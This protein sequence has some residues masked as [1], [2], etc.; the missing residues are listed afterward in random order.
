MSRCWTIGGETDCEIIVD[1]PTVS[2]RHCRLIRFGD[3]YLLEDLG[4]T[5]GTFV[6]GVRV[7]GRRTVTVHDSVTLGP[8]VPL[9]WPT[10][11]TAHRT[12]LL[13]GREPQNDLIVDRPSVSGC[14]ALVS[15]DPVRGEA[16]IE[17]LG[18]ANGTAIGSPTRKITRAVLS[19]VDTI[20]LG[21]EP[22]PAAHVL[23]Q[24]ATARA[25]KVVFKG[26]EMVIG[27]DPACQHVI[28]S[29]Q[30]SGRH[31][32]L[33]RSGDQVLIEDLRSSNGTFVNGRRIEKPVIIRD[34]DSIGL[35]SFALE[36]A[37]DR[38]HGGQTHAAARALRTSIESVPTPHGEAPTPSSTVRTEFAR[39]FEKPWRL[40]LLGVH[41][42]LLAMVVLLLA[43]IRLGATDGAGGG[44]PNARVVTQV[45]TWVATC[46]VWLGL[47]NAVFNG[48]LD[49]AWLL[50]GPRGANARPYA[51]RLAIVT[52]LC[53]LQCSLLW[54]T[55][56]VTLRLDAPWLP[57]LSILT[58]AS[59]A[60]L[61]AGF[62]AV[63]LLPRRAYVL[64][65]LIVAI[66]FLGYFGTVPDRAHRAD[67]SQTVSTLAPNRWACEG[68]ILLE[69]RALSGGDALAQ[70][71]ILSR[72]LVEAAFPDVVQQSG[73]VASWLALAFTA[74]GM[75]AAIALISWA[76][77]LD[78][79]PESVAEAGSAG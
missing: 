34:G 64:G 7:N 18:S 30:V 53:V 13:I 35:G 46:S 55:A 67:W 1:L 16:V 25:A 78:G 15:W 54:F 28:D 57:A 9:P 71:G 47:T 17:D 3:R 12:V 75:I 72:E 32:R 10:D 42:L 49:R 19:P 66:G 26:T 65:Y 33:R 59:A 29:P 39:A 77:I 4:S 40:V 44:I 38:L 41:S 36:F 8:A 52:S 20:Y 73:I 70:R 63:M 74:G 14:H 37:V 56:A 27:R 23:S 6:N 50:K 51:V 62:L 45:L 61:G 5:N 60:G 48:L 79:K 68:L 43:A 76:A 31:A 58:L 21:T 69:R 22:L 11:S 2:G 24:F